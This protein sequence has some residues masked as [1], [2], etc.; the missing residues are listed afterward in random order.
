MQNRVGKL[1]EKKSQSKAIVKEI[2]TPSFAKTVREDSPQ[3]GSNYKEIQRLRL[4]NSKLLTELA[5]AKE[6]LKLKE[7]FA[8][9]FNKFIDDK[10]DQRRMNM[11][12][13]K[14]Q[15]Q[16]RIVIGYL[17]LFNANST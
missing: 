3:S 8:T 15:K 11:Y 7:E 17:D 9:V 1:T 14:V 5:S 10:Y 13:A 6:E 12:K 2:L 4:E 16:D